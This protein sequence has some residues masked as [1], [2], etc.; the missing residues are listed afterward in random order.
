M[1]IHVL[2]S[3]NY[4]DCDQVELANDGTQDFLEVPCKIPGKLFGSVTGIKVIV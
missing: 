4:S 2:I 3:H 1:F